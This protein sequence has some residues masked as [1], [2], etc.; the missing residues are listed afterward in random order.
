MAVE[1]ASLDKN[2]R[3]VIPSHI[4][5][6]MGW[7]PG[8]RLTLS[9]LDNELRV[10]S[11]RQALDMLRAELRQHLA[12]GVSLA[13]ELIRERREEARREDEEYRLSTSRHKNREGQAAKE[14][15][16]RDRA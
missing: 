5:K 1:L 2:G 12:P 8:E 4:R 10:L 9:T 14:R 11:P 16:G 3:L 7:K 6:Q 13:D 15:R